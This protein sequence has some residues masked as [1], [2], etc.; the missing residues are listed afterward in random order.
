MKNFI[1][2]ASLALA[3]SQAAFAAPGASSPGVTDT[4]IYL[5]SSIPLSGPNAAIGKAMQEGSSAY[6]N[7]VNAGGGINGRKI[8]ISYLDDGYQPERAK[9]NT[10]KSLA[11]DSGA[12]ALFG[13]FGTATALAA[14][15][16]FEASKTPFF[17]P[18]S[19]SAAL[20][21][22]NNG[23]PKGNP[24]IFNVRAS[25]E[26]EVRTIV[27]AVTSAGYKR[28]G[29]VQQEDAFGEAV[30][31]MVKRELAQ[32][33]LQTVVTTKIPRNSVDASQAAKDV[34]AS[35]AEVVLLGILSGPVSSFVSQYADKKTR[36]PLM[37]A[38]SP[39]GTSQVESSLGKLADGLQI[40]QVVPNIQS[41]AI[42]IVHEY[43]AAMTKS[44]FK[45][46]YTS[47][48]FFIS[49]KIFA[50]GIE[51]AGKDLTQEK[52]EAS[53]NKMAIR[54]F[55]GFTAN[56]ADSHSGSDLVD[57]ITLDASGKYID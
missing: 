14:R 4:A 16:L 7:Q 39:V 43:R 2:A 36:R 12:F 31:Q 41:D 8:V 57:I 33:G 19:G 53:L 47:L 40:S 1:L 48:E 42:P 27:D 50:A 38:L 23:N 17:A 51:A 46:N 10:R 30:G 13:Y 3:I 20:R 18:L 11:S 37:Y 55:G 49:A 54:D 32:K 22:S 56:F 45:P 6:F 25:Y 26:E 35:T 44:H 29:V 15:P 9:E 28:I 52:F 5:F 21:T 34:M 24:L